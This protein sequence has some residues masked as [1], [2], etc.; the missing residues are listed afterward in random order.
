MQLNT[1][2]ILTGHIE[3]VFDALSDFARAER[4]AMSR[5]ISVERLDA[6][7]AP[8]EG[9]KWRIGFF[10][11]GRDREAEME[12][13]KFTRPTALRYEGHVGGLFFETN[14]ACRVADS[15]AT[16]VT[17][18]IKLRAKSMSARV[19]LQSLKIARRR[20]QQRFRKSIRNILREVEAS[21]S[22]VAR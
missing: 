16:E 4:A 7:G 22:S 5:G 14:V 6:L 1:T 21:R 17:V 15:N 20:V 18:A 11:R 10:A 8:G 12:V 19:L 3:D 9:V 2:E 13:T